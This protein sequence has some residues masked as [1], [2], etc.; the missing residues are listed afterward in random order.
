[1]GCRVKRTLSK[2]G[3]LSASL[4]ALPAIA[5]STA[6]IEQYQLNMTRGVTDIS[7]KV[8]DLHMLMFLVCVVIAIGVFGAMFWAMWFHRKSKGVKPANFHESIKVE[9]AWTVIPFIILIVIAV[10]AAKLLIDMEDANEPDYSGHWVTM[11]MA[12]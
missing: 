10:P 2:M 8:Y 1:M 6:K 12:L 5:E 7:E 4:L 9:I 3:L 11:E